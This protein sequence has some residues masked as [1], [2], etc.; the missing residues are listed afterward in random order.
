MPHQEGAVK[1][2]TLAF[3]VIRPFRQ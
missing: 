3:K 1:Y 2:L